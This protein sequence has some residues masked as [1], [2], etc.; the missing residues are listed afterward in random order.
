[1]PNPPAIL[2]EDFTT[3]DLST[4]YYSDNCLDSQLTVANNELRCAWVSQGGKTGNRRAELAIRKVLGGGEIPR[5]DP[6]GS[7]RWYSWSV[8]HGSNWNP[9]DAEKSHKCV[10]GQFHQTSGSNPP[11]SF[12][13]MNNLMRLTLVTLTVPRRFYAMGAPPADWT[14]I[15][16]NVKWSAGS[17]GFLQVW[18]DGVQLINYTGGTCNP[19]SVYDDGL[20][21]KGW[22]Y[23]PGAADGD[24]ESGYVRD[25]YVKDWRI[26]DETNVLEDMA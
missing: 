23:N 20:N 15:V 2:L 12:E 24:F 8:K 16:V 13:I 5:R 21:H 1:V 10:V 6:V 14:R 9:N 18:R 17:D 22:N 19:G 11:I 25:V 7:T 3:L 4:K 26:G